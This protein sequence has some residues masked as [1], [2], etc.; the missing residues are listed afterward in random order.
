MKKIL[1][2]IFLTTSLCLAAEDLNLPK[3]AITTKTIS[4]EGKPLDLT[5][6][7][8]PDANKPIPGFLFFH[9]G[10][11]EHEEFP[12]HEQFLR[13]IVDESGTG[14]VFVNFNQDPAARN[15]TAVQQA[16]A[17]T[18][19]IAEHGEE[20]GINGKCLAVSGMEGGGNLATVVC[21]LAKAKKQPEIRF[22]LL[23][24]PMTDS[25]FNTKSYDEFASGSSSAK[26]L[27][28]WFLGNPTVQP[29][30]QTYN[31]AP[32]Q[33][34]VAQLKGLPPALIIIAENDKIKGENLAYQR[35][36][37]A[38]GIA[39]T[40]LTYSG[41]IHDFG[42]LNEVGLAVGSDTLLK[43]VSQQLKEHLKCD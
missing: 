22:Q 32:L 28:Q 31:N 20:V 8:P 7:L 13:N 39:V 36:L 9:A 34:T 18:L 29:Q 25:T 10:G 24:W 43:Q 19:W 17:A 27:F 3:T 40:S 37:E 23:F 4:V 30:N 16:Y 14:A 41:V 1:S 11:Y 5:I 42:L 26:S 21:M 6:V 38:A 15:P 33:A 12:S 2:Y 35:Q